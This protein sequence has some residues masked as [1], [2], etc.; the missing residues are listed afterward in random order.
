MGSFLLIRQRSRLPKVDT[1][2]R[3]RVWLWVLKYRGLS[4]CMQLCRKE[5]GISHHTPLRGMGGGPLNRASPATPNRCFKPPAQPLIS[6]EALAIFNSGK[7]KP[8]VFTAMHPN[9]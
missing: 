9:W 1:L 3:S 2:Y 7:E 4:A 5:K 8:K 6:T